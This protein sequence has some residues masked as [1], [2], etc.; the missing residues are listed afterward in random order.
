MREASVN[1]GRRNSSQV[2]GK[3][4]AVLKLSEDV[5]MINKGLMEEND[6]IRAILL[7]LQKTGKSGKIGGKERAE[8][9]I[10]RTPQF[11]RF[12]ESW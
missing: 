11:K 12:M 5:E 1:R 4:K 8:W 2:E 10:E 9:K 6:R 7:C 3:R